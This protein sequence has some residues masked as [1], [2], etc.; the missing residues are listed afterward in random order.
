MV[1]N[2]QGFFMYDVF[3]YVKGLKTGNSLLVFINEKEV[4]ATLIRRGRDNVRVQLKDS[5]E[6]VLVSYNQ[7]KIK[8]DNSSS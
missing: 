7:I 2:H 1:I 5:S 4:E 8:S 6:K 3:D